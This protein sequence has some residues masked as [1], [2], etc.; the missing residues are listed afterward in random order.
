MTAEGNMLAPL[1]KEGDVRLMSHAM[2]VGRF[3]TS[4]SNARAGRSCLLLAES[5][6]ALPQPTEE[7]GK[8]SANHSS[9]LTVRYGSAAHKPGKPSRPQS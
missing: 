4:M 8:L 9:Q 6:Q 3:A 5:L 7:L 2:P 1:A